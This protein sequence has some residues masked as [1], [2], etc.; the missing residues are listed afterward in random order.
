MHKNI[1]DLLEQIEYTREEARLNVKGSIICYQD[2]N[3]EIAYITENGDSITRDF[4]DYFQEGKMQVSNDNKSLSEMDPYGNSSVMGRHNKLCALALA[5]AW[6]A[7]KMAKHSGEQKRQ[8]IP[9]K[10]SLLFGGGVI[11][12][13]AKMYYLLDLMHTYKFYSPSANFIKKI[14]LVTDNIGS[15]NQDDKSALMYIEFVLPK[16]D[17]LKEYCV[18]FHIKKELNKNKHQKEDLYKKLNESHPEY[19]PV[20]V[21]YGSNNVEEYAK[22]KAEYESRPYD[23]K[24]YSAMMDLV[25]YFDL[26]K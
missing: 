10:S 19:L 15:T 2:K 9:L 17:K 22:Y 4:E 25:T 14:V 5:N 18:S 11:L 12:Y 6:N 3:D 20:G 7:S 13:N 8:C 24:G 1:V 21:R 23:Q 16:D 26:K